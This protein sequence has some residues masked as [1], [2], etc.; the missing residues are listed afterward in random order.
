MNTNDK[1]TI[2]L[3]P[4][5]GLIQLEDIKQNDTFTL[6]SSNGYCAGTFTASQAAFINEN[7]IWEVLAIDKELK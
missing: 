6:Y 4:G 2:R 5:N 7:G 3:W 1:R